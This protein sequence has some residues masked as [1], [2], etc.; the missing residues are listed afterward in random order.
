MDTKRETKEVKTSGGHTAV[1]KT[2]AT[3]REFNE[4]QG[5]YLKSAQVNIINGQPA[6][7]GLSAET[8]MEASKKMIEMLVVMLDDSDENLVD[9]VLDLPLT[10]YNEVIEALSE[11][12]GKKKK[13]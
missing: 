5:V 1:I 7:S 3:G 8:E 6:I 12:S 13:E 11:I 2:Y 10:D 4:I 9:R